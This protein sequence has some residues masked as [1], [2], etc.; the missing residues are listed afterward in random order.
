MGIEIERKFLL[1]NNDW[2]AAVVSESSLRQGFLSTDPERT[3]RVR[4]C[5][6]QGLLTI[7]GLTRG[8]R[9]L[10][11]EYPIP[12]AEAEQLLSDLCLRPLIEKTRY[13]VPYG[14]LVWEIDVFA[15]DNVGLVVAEI[16]L[17]DETQPFA[18]P[19]WIGDEVTGDPRYYNANLIL[20][21]YS[22]WPVRL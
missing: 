22:T 5:D 13:Q 1:R 15:G 6:N 2:R 19:P 18:V 4:L 20:R 10:E 11:F 8:A 16:E 12:A 14:G 3:L 7:K 17:E 21:P 9:R